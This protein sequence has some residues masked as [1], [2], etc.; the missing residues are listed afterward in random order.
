[1]DEAEGLDVVLPTWQVTEASRADEPRLRVLV[2][3]AVL[4]LMIAGA[5]RLGVSAVVVGTAVMGVLVAVGWPKLLGLPSPVGA[6]VALLFSVAAGIL[7]VTVPVNAPGPKL[8]FVPLALATSLFAA[9]TRELARPPGRPRLV[10][11]IAG[12]ACGQVVAVSGATWIALSTIDECRVA[13]PVAAAAILGG[14]LP[15]PLA[16]R[17]SGRRITP[18]AVVLAGAGTAYLTHVVLEGQPGRPVLLLAV[19]GVLAICGYLARRVLSAAPA[20]GGL[21]AQ[22]AVAVATLAAVGLPAY[23]LFTALP[24]L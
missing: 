11:S 8:Q 24:G 2:T 9:L 7:A 15:E 4:A 16:A 23:T 20:I 14:L 19:C 10:E 21:A 22:V 13:G 5:C 17:R 18:Y 3:T 6:T 12:T 1:M